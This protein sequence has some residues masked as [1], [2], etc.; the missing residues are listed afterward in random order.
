MKRK[1]EL[2]EHEKECLISTVGVRLQKSET[3][4]RKKKGEGERVNKKQGGKRR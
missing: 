3:Q 2:Q 4:N 1:G